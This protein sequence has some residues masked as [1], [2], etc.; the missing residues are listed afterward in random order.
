MTSATLARRR[1]LRRRRRARWG[2]AGRARRPRTT[3][4]SAV[5]STTRGRRSCTWR[6]TCRRRAA[7]VRARRCST[8][9]PSWSQAAGGRTLGLFSSRRAAVAAAE[10]MR[11]RLD[12]AVLCQGDDVT[13]DPRA[14]RSP[15][16]PR[17]CLFGTL[18]LWQGVDVPGSACQLVVVD[19]IPFPRPDD[20]LAVGALRGS[21]A[22]RGQRVHAVSAAHAALRLAQG[23]GRL[24]PLG[25]GPRRGRGARPAAR[26]RPLRAVPA[27]VAAADVGDDRPDA[28]RDALRRIDAA[29]GPVWPVAGVVAE[30]G[31]PA[32]ADG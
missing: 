2:C 30:S 26:H 18:S 9:S 25:R 21:G 23:V 16:T 31:E 6:G 20:P 7:M 17:T 22:G 3:S 13:P 5:R 4:T 27:G 8:S 11:A 28:V 24:D 14:R 29:A 1:Q 19:R 32:A 15:A 10:A 12:V